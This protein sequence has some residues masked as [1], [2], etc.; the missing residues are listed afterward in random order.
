MVNLGLFFW[1]VDQGAEALRYIRER[2][3]ALPDDYG[4]RSSGST[5]RRR[6]SSPS[7]TTS[8]P[9]TCSRSSA[10]D[11][12]RS[13]RRR[14]QPV[15]ELFPPLFELRHADPVRR[16]PADARRERAVG[17]PRLR[18]GVLPRRAHRRRDRGDRRALPPEGVAD[19][20]HADVPDGRR[21]P[22]RRRRRHRVRR[23]P[24]VEVAGQHRRSRARPRPAR[25]RSRVGARHSG[26]PCCSSPRA[27]PATST[28]SPTPTRTGCAPPT[29][30]RST[31][32]SPGSRPSTTPTTSS[33]R[34]PTSSPHRRSARTQLRV[35]IAPMGAMRTRS[36]SRLAAGVHGRTPPRVG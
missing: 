3:A 19:V 21:V 15:R 24:R 28:S 14:S 36:S 31:T 5:R 33:T 25:D 10:G 27:A 12:P 18:E 1:G 11:R 17:H 20:D 9:A 35:L 30:R 13:T 8:R 6:R 2:I 23:Q 29:A 16:T 34:T 26:R 32:G 7:S 22:R 4:R